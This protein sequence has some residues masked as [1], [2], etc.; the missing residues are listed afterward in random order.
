MKAVLVNL[1]RCCG[2]K[3]CQV[4]CKD[5]HC[6]QPWLPYAEAQPEIG[7]FWM[8]VLEDVQGQVPMSR[9]VYTPVFCGHCDDAP[10]LAAAKD[11]AVYRREEDG[12]IIIDPVK[13]KGQKAI[14]EAC[15]IGA[16][17]WND[18]LDI[19]QKCTGCA[20]LMDNGWE[21][22]RC[23][24][25]CNTDALYF[26]EEEELLAKFPGAHVAEGLE[27]FGS[28]VYFVGDLKYFV[29]GSVVDPEEDEAIIGADV[30][31]KTANNEV[32][33][34]QKTDEFG[35][36][37]F[38]GIDRGK[39]KVIIAQEGFEDE[40]LNADASENSIYLGVI[41]PTKEWSH[42]YTRS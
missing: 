21:T 9:V 28:H 16:I 37:Q 14:K 38:K 25:V 5:E 35:E 6:E 30:V 32:V 8:N 41:Y 3:N 4:A 27:G 22:P 24:D 11:G 13:A 18:A 39:Y 26:G 12:L 42:P 1:A 34:T 17:Y 10:C 15:P 40:Y 23:L 36:F 7:Q 2:C 20:H 33:A 31:L 29:G 19:P